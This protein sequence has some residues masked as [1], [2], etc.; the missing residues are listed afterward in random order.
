[1]IV[2]VP[3]RDPSAAGVNVTLIVQ[4]ASAAT[5]DAQLVVWL[6]SPALVPVIPIWFTVRA[7]LLESVS[8]T[9]CAALCVPTF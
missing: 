2:N 9:V 1:V 6:K 5:L 8:V 4:L 3:D 7:A